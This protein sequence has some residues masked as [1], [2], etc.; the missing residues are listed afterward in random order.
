MRD[1][2]ERSTS[3][4]SSRDINLNNMNF[5]PVR[6]ADSKKESANG[7]VKDGEMNKDIM[8]TLGEG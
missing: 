6:G 4:L 3:C 5:K 8:E 2:R 7:G 1:I